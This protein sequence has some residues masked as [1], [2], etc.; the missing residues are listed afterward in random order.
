MG[1]C[2]EQTARALIH[3]RSL[4]WLDDDVAT[5]VSAMLYWDAR[6]INTRS[7]IFADGCGEIFRELLLCSC[8]VGWPVG[9]N[10]LETD[11]CSRNIDPFR[12]T[13][14]IQRTRHRL[15]RAI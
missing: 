2:A 6:A 12:T 9:K 15:L 14:F 5:S 11:D 13:R 1:N 8:I 7:T 10:N 3:I 4:L